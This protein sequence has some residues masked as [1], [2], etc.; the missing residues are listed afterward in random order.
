MKNKVF[1]RTFSGI[2]FIIIVIGS[3]IFGALSFLLLFSLLTIVIEVEFYNIAK[4]MGVKPQ[5]INGIFVSLVLFF[6]VALNA[7]GIIGSQIMFLIMPLVFLIYIFE[8]FQ[9]NKNAFTNI[10]Y[11]IIGII[12]IALP[13]TFMNYVVFSPVSPVSGDTVVS[14]NHLFN[15][16]LHASL[17]TLG[18]KTIS[19]DP[20]YMI[21]FL[22]LIWIND[23]FAYLVGLTLGRNP[24]VPYVSPRKT[25]EG[26]WGG[27]FFVIIAAL[28]CNH[29]FTFMNL[30]D[31][32]VTA[33]IIIFFGTFGDLT[34]SLLKRSVHIKDSGNILPGHG[35]MLDRFDSFLLAA[36][37]YFAYILMIKK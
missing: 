35:G 9:K 29:Y 3:F 26:F 6:M 30:T 28:A 21:A 36:P 22:S 31:W 37:V 17:F 14:F 12:Y 25:W 4:K 5:M 34:E 19:F 15:E 7:L 32:L 2:A 20:S 16:N 13:F 18:K 33:F 24:L 10:T 23:T 27:A 11:T 8:I 1:I